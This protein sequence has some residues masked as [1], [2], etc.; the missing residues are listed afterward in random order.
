MKQGL[1]DSVI[2]TK[3]LGKKLHIRTDYNSIGKIQYIAGQM[4]YQFLDTE[5]SDVV[6]AYLMVP[7]GDVDAFTKKVTEATSGK[8]DIDYLEEVYYTYD[9]GE[10]ILFD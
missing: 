5:Y 8:A 3:S 6:D 2:V 7:I 9:T 10:L 4:Q 1:E